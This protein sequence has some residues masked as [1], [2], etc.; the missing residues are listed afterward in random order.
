MDKMLSE[1]V[2]VVRNED[3][4]E[5]EE[6][7]EEEVRS[8]TGEAANQGLFLTVDVNIAMVIDRLVVHLYV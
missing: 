5:R 2:F 4:F 1:E 8:C 7:C 3:N 6:G